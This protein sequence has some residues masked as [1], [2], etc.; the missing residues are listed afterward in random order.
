[1]PF[2]AL[3]E[4]GFL[5]ISVKFYWTD[6][7]S[8]TGSDQLQGSEKKELPKTSHLLAWSVGALA[9]SIMWKRVQ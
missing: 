9:N 1:M 4:Q 7:L 8:D 6:A 5:Y 2:I 3:K